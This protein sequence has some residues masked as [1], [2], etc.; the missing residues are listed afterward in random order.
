[1]DKNIS[2]DGQG[3]SFSNGTPQD[4]SRRRFLKKGVL[5]MGAA[6]LPASFDGRA[7]TE[8][9]EEWN[10]A[11]R[12]KLVER[13]NRI[14]EFSQSLLFYFAGIRRVQERANFYLD[15]PPK[16][17]LQGIDRNILEAYENGRHFFE[18]THNG[19]KWERALLQAA[20]FCI[21]YIDKVSGIVIDTSLGGNLHTEV[22]SL[23]KQGIWSED[24]SEMEDRLQNLLAEV[25]D[26]S[27]KMT[28]FLSEEPVDDGGGLGYNSA[29][30]EVVIFPAARQQLSVPELPKA[31]TIGAIAETQI[32]VL[33]GILQTIK[34]VQK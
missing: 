5:T 3:D 2:L 8:S 12:A 20:R 24:V 1:M 21:N 13:L 33:L 34:G 10:S 32:H 11:D 28:A 26:E 17:G 7:E 6:L 23:I 30:L 31:D 4:P 22:F 16:N 25:Q 18:E 19:M 29:D 15:N 14:R 27:R 9:M